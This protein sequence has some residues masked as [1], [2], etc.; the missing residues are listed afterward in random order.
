LITIHLSGQY[1]ASDLNR[2]EEWC[3]YLA[4]ELNSVGYDIQIST[5]TNWV[6]TDMRTSAEMERI[7]TNIRAL[8]TGYHYITNIYQNAEYFDYQKAN[9]WEQIL[10]EIYHLMFGMR[11][12]YVYGGVAR[13]GQPRLWQ[14]RFRQLTKGATLS[15]IIQDTDYLPYPAL[16]NWVFDT[17]SA[18]TEPSAGAEFNYTN[19]YG[20][21][22]AKN[23]SAMYNSSRTAKYSFSSSNYTRRSIC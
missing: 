11:N 13:G 8:M 4:D 17:E 21:F 22:T 7:R 14:H 3:R 9:N 20:T 10:S 16:A 15:V 2:V 6:Q 18:E 1:N 19:D 12:W 5:K 23:I